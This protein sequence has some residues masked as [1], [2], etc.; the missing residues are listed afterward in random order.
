MNLAFLHDGFAYSR[1]ESI[2]FNLIYFPLLVRTISY[3]FEFIVRNM[4]TEEGKLNNIIKKIKIKKYFF[5]GF[6]YGIF[7]GSLKIILWTEL[8]NFITKN[9]DFF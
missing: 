8:I 4:A 6:G 2:F 7:K 3:P 1:T 5:R 9:E